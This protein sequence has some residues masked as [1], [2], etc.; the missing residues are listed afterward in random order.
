METNICS[1][2]SL[3]VA[4]KRDYKRASWDLEYV[5][6]ALDPT[7]VRAWCC[8]AGVNK[9]MG[10]DEG[11]EYC[12]AKARLYGRRTCSEYVENFVV[13]IKSDF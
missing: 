1:S 10:N 4:R 11:Y 12:I 5:V 9:R 2:I 6:R 7:C 3:F 13:K 8:L